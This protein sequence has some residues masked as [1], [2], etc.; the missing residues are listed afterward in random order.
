MAPHGQSDVRD[1]SRPP[2]VDAE[3][4]CVVTDLPQGL[5]PCQ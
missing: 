4:Y 2:E 3:E 1:V 5:F